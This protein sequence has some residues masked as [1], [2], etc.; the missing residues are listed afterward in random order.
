MI[1]SFNIY[2][3]NSTAQA[4][5]TP[6]L[7]SLLPPAPTVRSRITAAIEETMKMRPCF[8]VKHFR[9]R[10]EN[11]FN[12]AKEEDGRGAAGVASGST[13]AKADLARSLFFPSA[14]APTPVAASPRP[15]P[16][17]SF[18]ASVSA[19][20][21]LGV[22]VC[23]ENEAIGDMDAHKAGPSAKNPRLDDNRSASSQK[24]ATWNKFSA[25]GLYALS[26]QSMAAFEMAHTYDLD[27]VITYLLQIIYLLHDS[28]P[29]VAHYVY[30][31]LGKV[32]HIAHMMGLS[33]DPD[34]FP[35]K[36][37]LFE[38]EQRRRIWWDIYYYDVFISD[39][40]GQAPSIQDGTYTTKMPADVDEE[41]FSPSSTSLPLPVPR[42]AGGDPT[43]VGFA[44][45]IQKCRFV[46]TSRTVISAQPDRSH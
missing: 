2:Y 18:F 1:P 29:R 45:F 46:P 14:H 9:S 34:E 15:T 17:L 11:M 30:P 21:A 19:A 4:V 23:K 38:A 22:L 36:Y 43:E 41:Q 10:A 8:N 26:R 5:V 25:S 35:G 28:R 39:A 42:R 7:V 44:Y 33:T 6:S 40:M 27:S 32:I 20:Y 37:S 3:P 31:L 12:W 13:N 16:T 24:A